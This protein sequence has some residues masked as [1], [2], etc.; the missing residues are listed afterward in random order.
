MLCIA[1][2]GRCGSSA[3]MMMLDAGGY[4]VWGEPPDYEPQYMPY[5][6]EHIGVAVKTLMPHRFGV[7][8]GQH[9]YIW[10]DRDRLEQAKSQVKLAERKGLTKKLSDRD[11]E[12]AIQRTLWNI[13]KERGLA[14]NALRREKVLVLSYE[15]LLA[16]PENV[17]KRIEKFSRRNLDICAMVDMIAIRSPACAE[18]FLEADLLEAVGKK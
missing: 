9:R 13:P 2:L 14:M 6:P 8:L 18:T 17:A 7:P 3:V 10:L 1:G 12:I 15:K 16:D 11:R 4:P 5:P